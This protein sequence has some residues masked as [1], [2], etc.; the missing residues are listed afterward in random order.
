MLLLHAL[1]AWNSGDLIR[2]GYPDFA[3]FYS[4]AKLIGRGLGSHIYDEASEYRVQQEFAE[5]VSIRHGAF[6]YNHPPFEA[7]LF[8]PLTKLAF[9][10]AFLCWD[11]LNLIMLGII[12]FLL[13]P[14]LPELQSY[15]PIYLFVAILAFFP[16][17]FTLLQGQ[18]AIVLLFLYSL[19]FVYLKKNKLAAAGA[20]M[21]LGLFK[22]HLVVPVLVL[23]MVQR[24]ADR[25]K[26]LLL[27]F[28]PAAC[29]VAV[30]S[31]A[32]V[33]VKAIADY[34]HYVLHLEDTMARGA[35]VP[36]DM[37]NLRGML[38]VLLP[39]GF[40]VALIALLLSLAL[41]LFAAWKIRDPGRPE[42]FDLRFSLAL[43]AT[44][45]VSYHDMCYDL[46]I[47]VLA[48]LLMCNYRLAQRPPSRWPDVLV[49][50]AMAALFFA[51]LHIILLIRYTRFALMGLVVLVLFWGMSLHLSGRQKTELRPEAVPAAG[52]LD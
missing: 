15:S 5:G 38:Y 49:G 42:T 48:M 6:P 1:L 44:V 41:L 23:L 10:P 8:V 39:A 52:G 14:Y 43:V 31:V 50:S 19:A 26:Q 7:L 51:P 3:A 4:A 36:E 28:L 13:R 40:P 12:L 25:R 18:D 20:L 46:S 29:A 32:V 21:A 37:P 45:L 47:L 35:I 2:H 30:A 34:P 24:G 22:P 16:V 27:G 33:G 9:F 17:F 11:L